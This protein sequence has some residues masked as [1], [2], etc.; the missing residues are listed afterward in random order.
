MLT[1]EKKTLTATFS[2]HPHQPTTLT[3]T[4]LLTVFSFSFPFSFF[5]NFST[6]LCL[7]LSRYASTLL[8]LS[9]HWHPCTIDTTTDHFSSFLLSCFH[10]FPSFSPPF[11]LFHFFSFPL[12]F[13]FL[14]ISCS[15]Q[16]HGNP[17]SNHLPLPTPRTCLDP[18]IRAPREMQTMGFMWLLGWERDWRV[19]EG[20]V[21]G[22][23]RDEKSL[24]LWGWRR[25]FGK[26]RGCQRD[27]F[28][29]S[30]C[31]TELYLLKNEIKSFHISYAIGR[32]SE[33]RSLES[34]LKT[35]D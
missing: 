7:L 16:P 33:D 27:F 29:I 1:R 12:L 18:P 26:R 32:D 22:K 13:V 4:F 25:E 23:G 9:L 28:K 3:T 35:D 20:K 34:N 21:R 2:P 17:A 10:F 14:P 19:A 11:L 24:D 15:L 5:F 6:L 8:S 31:A 30:K